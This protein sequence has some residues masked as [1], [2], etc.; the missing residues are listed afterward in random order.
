WAVIDPAGRYDASS[1]G[2]VDGLHFVA[3]LEPIALS[4]LKERY[5][6]PGLLAKH[7]GL[8]DDPP[9]DVSGLQ[10]VKLYPDIAVT[11]ADPKTPQKFDVALTNRGGGIGRVV[12]LVNGK[13][14]TDDA[15]PRKALDANA[16]KLDV[17]VD[18]S[19]DPRIVP[20]QK[21]TVEVLAYNAD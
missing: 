17:R 19:N 13:E 21:N 9:R 15:R 18:L 12:V 6:D 3:G 7:L 4:Q 16:A 14:R 5:Y 8:G 2:D 11:Q 10:D 20:G 1:G